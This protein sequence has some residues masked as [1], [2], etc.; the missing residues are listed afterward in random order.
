MQLMSNAT[1]TPKLGPRAFAVGAALGLLLSS[2][3]GPS[4]GLVGVVSSSPSERAPTFEAEFATKDSLWQTESGIPRGGVS[5]GD[6]NA[7]A[8]DGRVATLVLPGHPE[9]DSKDGAGPDLATAL[10]LNERFGY[11]TY[12]SRVAFGGCSS[13]EEATQAV[14]GYFSDGGDHNENGIRD[15]T[16]IDFQVV[17]GAPAFAYLTVFTDYEARPSGEVFRKLSHVVDFATGRTYDTPSASEDVFAAGATDPTLILPSFSAGTFYELGF[18]WH[19]DKIRFFIDA[20]AG[21]TT[22]WTLTDPARV[23]SGSVQMVY[24]AWHPDT[25]WFPL[26]GAADYP[27]A[28]VV[29]SV[30]RFRFY[31]E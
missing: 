6:A 15:E 11:G 21:E 20:G 12:R 22:L 4:D 3:C 1:P 30:D 10:S 13:G 7:A 24:N 27:A 29:M 14:L 25:H 2:G 8:G 5:L 26:S 31:A 17:C 19:A 18:E 28:D 9:Y 16:E 23:P